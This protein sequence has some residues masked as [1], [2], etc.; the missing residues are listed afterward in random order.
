MQ[1]HHTM[2]CGDK[3]LVR[4]NKKVSSLQRSVQISSCGSGQGN[5]IGPV[6]WCQFVEATFLTTTMVQIYLVHRWIVL[7]TTE[8]QCA[9]IMR[10][11]CISV[12]QTIMAKGC[13]CQE[14]VQGG[15]YRR[16]VNTG[17]FYNNNNYNII[18]QLIKCSCKLECP[19]M[20]ALQ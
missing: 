18:Y 11:V 17:A 2:F 9:K 1:C 19:L 10:S 6:C 15:V 16:C 14:T 13:L 7:C 3:Q 12:Y 5:R 20:S 4:L 8:L